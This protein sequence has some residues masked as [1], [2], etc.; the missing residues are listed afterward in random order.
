MKH[1]LGTKTSKFRTVIG[2]YPTLVL[3]PSGGKVN[4]TMKIRHDHAVQLA[5]LTHIQLGPRNPTQ[6]N[7]C[8]QLLSTPPSR[9]YG[10][11]TIFVLHLPLCFI[12]R[13]AS[14]AMEF[15]PEIVHDSTAL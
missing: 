6:Y 12:C 3:L 4:A 7:A 10:T 5:C 9:R 1:S 2:W 15:L 13:G 8:I 11:F 14:L